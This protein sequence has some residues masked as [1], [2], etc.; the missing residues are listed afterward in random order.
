[1]LRTITATALLAAAATANDPSG[2][3]L[4]YAEWTDP[5]GGRITAL[6]TSWTVPTNPTSTYGSNA[7]GWWFGVQ[8]A[9]GDGAL[10]Q[11]ILAYGYQGSEY[12]MFN[13]CFD[14]TDGSWHTSEEKYTV[15]PGDLITSSVTYKEDNSYDMMISSNGKSITT[16]YKIES[17]QTGNESTAY[18]VLE[19]QPDHCSAYPA[20]G[21]MTFSD[22]YM[23][24]DGVEVKDAKWAAKQ[25]QPM[26]DSKAVVVDASTISFTWDPTKATAAK[27]R[28]AP[29]MGT[30]AKWGPLTPDP[31][32]VTSWRPPT[33]AADSTA[34][35]NTTNTSVCWKGSYGRGVGKPISSCDA[36][37]GLE[38]S[39]E[40]CYPVCKT[41]SPSY[42]G[43]GPVCWEHCRSGYVD[44]GALCRE[45][46][47]IKTYAKKSYGRGA[48]YPLT[49]AAGQQEDA[50]LCYPPCNTGFYGV[51]PVCWESC[52]TKDPVSGGALCCVDGPT[53]SAKIKALAGGL[54]LAIAKA[55]LAGK[56]VKAVIQAVIDAINAVLGFV[57]PLCSTLEG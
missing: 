35:A 20:D 24:V 46:G 5:N 41:A 48:G 38:K 18:F 55:I 1:M 37:K 25:E 44:E 45:S 30:K 6:N 26:C 47:S 51:G 32:R 9:A 43:I 19:H 39:G 54:P 23:E 12:T 16:N 28:V 3:W 53:C 52:P 40:L 33:T 17:A 2:S 8:T 57:M 50:S 22:I 10:I 56:D 14:W 27:D 49:C 21:K 7:P 15:Q 34:S 11:P 31:A 4:S 36:S 42:Y 29:V 13:G